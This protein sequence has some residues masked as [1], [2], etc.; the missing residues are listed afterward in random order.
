MIFTISGRSEKKGIGL[1]YKP[2]PSSNEEGDLSLIFLPK[3]NTKHSICVIVQ[4]EQSS[5]WDMFQSYRWNVRA[6]SK[7]FYG[8]INVCVLLITFEIE[9]NHF[10]KC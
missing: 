10:N 2:Y 8:L 3:G 7:S 9:V 5:Y 4:G 1:D 6:D